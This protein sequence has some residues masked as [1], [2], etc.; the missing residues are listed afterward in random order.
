MR[1]SADERIH[2]LTVFIPL[3][4]VKSRVRLPGDIISRLRLRQGTH[5][6]RATTYVHAWHTCAWH[7]HAPSTSSPAATCT[8]ASPRSITS[9][10]AVQPTYQQCRFDVCRCRP[11]ELVSNER[12]LPE[13]TELS[14]FLSSFL[15]WMT[16]AQLNHWTKRMVCIR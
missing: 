3:T 9:C 12:A 8:A 13:S 6:A 16:N 4:T 11:G 2:G 15:S 10:I 5:A 7:T 14:S 1:S